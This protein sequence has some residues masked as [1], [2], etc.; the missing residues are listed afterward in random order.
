MTNISSIS[1]N[2]NVNGKAYYGLVPIARHQVHLH[3][4]ILKVDTLRRSLQPKQVLPLQ[5]E[6]RMVYFFKRS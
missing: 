6:K 3:W 1:L 2:V 4:A 5:E